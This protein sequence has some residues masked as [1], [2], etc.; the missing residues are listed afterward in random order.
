MEEAHKHNIIHRDLKPSNILLTEDDIPKITDF[1]LAK[2][3]DSAGQ[4]QSGAVLGT[5]SYMAPEQAAG[6]VREHGP[7]ADIY[8]LGASC[9][10]CWWVGRR[11][12][13]ARLWKRS[14]R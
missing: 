9:T 3:L 8:A 5:P 11:S 12:R 10:S 13:P 1:G 2:D 7:A 4:T 6:K 14:C